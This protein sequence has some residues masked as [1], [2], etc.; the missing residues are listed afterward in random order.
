MLFYRSAPAVLN[1][2]AVSQS[3]SLHQGPASITLGCHVYIIW[4]KNKCWP[5]GISPHE[6]CALRSAS[7]GVLQLARVHPSWVREKKVLISHRASVGKT[8]DN[9]VTGEIHILRGEPALDEVY[10]RLPIPLDPVALPYFMAPSLFANLY[11]ILIPCVLNI[12]KYCIS[13]LL[14]SEVEELHRVQTISVSRC[15]QTVD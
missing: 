8:G 7:A 12:L 14:R 4:F 13:S 9:G 11:F 10:L 6:R 1:Y 5:W 15:L 3:P 2:F